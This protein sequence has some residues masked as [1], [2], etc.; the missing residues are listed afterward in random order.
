MTVTDRW[1]RAD[2]TASAEKGRGK[3]WIVRYRDPQGKQRARS[4]ARKTDADRFDLANQVAI[5]ETT[6]VDPHSG[7]QTFDTF[8][9]TWLE[10]NKPHWKPTTQRSRKQIVKHR[11]SPHIGITPMSRISHAQVQ[12][13]VND[14]MGRYADATV[15]LNLQT[16]RTIMAAAM[17]HQVIGR[18][19][20]VKVKGPKQRRRRDAHLSH[21]DVATILTTTRDH[22]QP[23]MATL[24]WCGLRLGEALGLDVADV[25]FMTGTMSITKQLT[26]EHAASQIDP[27]PKTEAGVREVPVPQQLLQMLSGMLAD[28]RGPDGA[29]PSGPLWMSPHG[30]RLQRTTVDSE[31]R[32]VRQRT[33]I[34]FS[35]HWLRHF[36]GAALLSAGVPIPQVAK[37]MGHA[38]PQV[39]LKVYAYALQGD[40]HL[41]RAAVADV[42]AKSMSCAPDVHPQAVGQE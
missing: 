30:G 4:F 10:A 26:T 2:G 40:A 38:S 32:R 21:E 37:Q 5:V 12:A 13:M 19:P 42:A 24:A 39:T 22:V 20:S 9:A 14:W 7:K 6:W 8:A 15:N 25:D 34:T 1:H 23:F 28:R 29:P 11:I 27:L 31:I 18:D 33:G 41:G 35:A 36:Y 16:F 3:R 17:D